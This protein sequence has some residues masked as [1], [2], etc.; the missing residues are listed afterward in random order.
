MSHRQLP[1]AQV[2]VLQSWIGPYEVLEDKSWPLQDT[3]VQRVR[4]L[5]TGSGSEVFVKYSA[6]S[7]HIERELTAYSSGVNALGDHAPVLLHSS[8][9]HQM[10]AVS[11]LPGALVQGRA[12]ELAPDTHERA[13]TLLAR[14][15]QHRGWSTAY[16]PGLV[17]K[18]TRFMEQG[19]ALF[20]GG[21]ADSIHQALGTLYRGPVEVVLTHGDYQPRN[22]LI[23]DG[24][25]CVIDFGR[26]D[27]RPWVSDLVRLKNQQWIGRPD[28]QEAFMAGYGQ[29]LTETDAKVFAAESILQAV[30]TVVWAHDVGDGDFEEVGRMMLINALNRTW[31][32]PCLGFNA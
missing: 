20:S 29:A 31:L 15:H 18:T 19:H 8:R 12:E 13:G 32:L 24:I 6:T 14:L 23:E 10:F 1:A 7:H 3:T 9:V 22:W 27:V 30:G 25:V 28:L 5:R 17:R 11:S 2:S 21:D 16:L 26:A 4:P